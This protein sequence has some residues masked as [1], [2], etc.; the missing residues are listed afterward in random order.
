MRRGTLLALVALLTGAAVGSAGQTGLAG[1]TWQLAKLGGV[2]RESSGI[3]AVF[4]AAGR[5]SGFAGCNAYS[6]SYTTSGPAISIPNKLAV[7]RKSC[8]RLVDAQERAYLSA[9]TRARRYSIVGRTLTLK[10]RFGRG[11]AAFTVQSQSLAGTHWNV[12]SYNNGKQAVTS[13]MTSTKLTLDFGKDNVTGFAG[14]NNYNASVE[15]TPP[16]ISIGPVASTRKACSLPAGVMEQE[17]AYLTALGTAARFR[18][19]GTSLELRTTDGAIAVT[20]QRA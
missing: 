8:G 14:C 19:E 2:T 9:L 4:T 16:K 1:Q 7:T 11:L 6:G 3:T 17:G 13:V 18:L 5:V 10:S 12:V 20:A 15:V